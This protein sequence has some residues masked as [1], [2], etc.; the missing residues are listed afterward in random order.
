MTNDREPFPMISVI[1]VSSLL[2]CLFKC[3]SCSPLLI[4]VVWCLSI[5]LFKSFYVFWLQVLHQVHGIFPNGG[6]VLSLFKRG[7][8]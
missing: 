6:L 4:W 3:L 1:C 2:K 8:F 5:E 7:L